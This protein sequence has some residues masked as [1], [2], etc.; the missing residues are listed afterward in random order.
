LL[1]LVGLWQQFQQAA[2]AVR[3][4]ADL[5]DVPAEPQS[6]T[7]GRVAS[8]PGRIEL[9]GVSFRYADDRPWLYRRLDATIEPG[10]CVVVTGPSGCG[11]STLLKLLLGFALPG[12]GAVRLDG[13]D[14]R[15][16]AANELRAR[17]GVV[18]QE[19]TLFSGT[20]L[21][22]LQH[23]NAL[24]SFDQVAS[25]CRIAGIHAT[26]E[27]LPDGYMSEVGERGAGLSGGQ[28]Q[29]L[30]L[31]RALLRKPQVLLLDEPFSQLDDDSARAIA[32]A[33]SRLRGKLT[34]VIVSHQLPSTLQ[35]DRRIDL[36]SNSAADR[37]A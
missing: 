7:P 22:N 24:A 8:G 33:I 1:R 25:A 2:I 5:M 23:G 32:A 16:F 4:L 6:L 37:A 13:R 10:E 11:K 35:V 36:T 31:A 19:T 21:D 26:I 29:R 20:L 15:A 12:E 17:F 3:R 27:A 14:T 9:A 28:K 30:S 34:I 18:P